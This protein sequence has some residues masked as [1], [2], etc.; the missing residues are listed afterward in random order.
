MPRRIGI[1]LPD[2]PA[3]DRRAWG[4]ALEAGD[5]FSDG[6]IAS[7]W[8]PATRADAINGYSYWLR[9]L[10][11]NDPAALRLDPGERATRDRLHA[12]LQWLMSRVTAMGAAAALGHLALCLLYTSPSPRD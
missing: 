7:S 5:T 8:R 3:G 10:A 12:Y 1:S 4:Q 2:W 11:D 6:G 9:F